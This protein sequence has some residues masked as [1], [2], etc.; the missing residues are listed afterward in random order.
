MDYPN[1]PYHLEKTKT[2]S[3]ISFT[4]DKS[5]QLYIPFSEVENG[6]YPFTGRGFTGS[7]NIVLLEYKLY[8]DHVFIEGDMIS[9]HNSQIGEII[10]RYGF[11]ED[12]GWIFLK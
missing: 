3:K 12:K 5:D 2:Y 10:K 9:I 7:D 11:K 6:S 4:L 1:T 8:K